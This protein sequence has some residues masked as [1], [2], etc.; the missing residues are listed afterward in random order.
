MV[1]SAFRLQM[2][3]CT[4]VPLSC[5]F[6]FSRGSLPLII[7][8]SSELPNPIWCN[9]LISASQWQRYHYPPT[10]PPP[11]RTQSNWL[12]N[13]RESPTE[14]HWRLV[15]AKK[16]LA[17]V[18]PYECLYGLEW[19]SR[20]SD[21]VGIRHTKGGHSTKYCCE[22][23][24]TVVKT[25]ALFRCLVLSYP[26]LSWPFPPCSLSVSIHHSP[27]QTKSHTEKHKL[28]TI[29]LLPEECSYLCMFCPYL[30]FQYHRNQRNQ[31]PLWW[32]LGAALLSLL[33]DRG[34][35][36]GGGGA[37]RRWGGG[38]LLLTSLFFISLR[39]WTPNGT[40]K[41]N[42]GL[43]LRGWKKGDKKSPRDGDNQLLYK[44]VCFFYFKEDAM[45]LRDS[46]TGQCSYFGIG[47]V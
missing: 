13:L 27:T 44:V 36:A 46:S 3:S 28:V 12:A 18:W 26:V 2:S 25:P 23:K 4:T 47:V 43:F 42:T 10:H 11:N 19:V 45:M 20:R 41:S 1:E 39:N 22:Q 35:I 32:R 40:V 7:L 30:L 9:Y 33:F 8:S 6:V 21:R 37:G 34:F 17:K 15:P 31:G 5:R 16:K 24:Q 29:S 14:P 38:G